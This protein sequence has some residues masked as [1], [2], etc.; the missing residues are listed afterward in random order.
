MQWT[1]T[2]RSP[3]RFR[4]CLLLAV[5]LVTGC[6]DGAGGGNSNSDPADESSRA[7]APAVATSALVVETAAV[8]GGELTVLWRFAM[9]DDWH[10]Y[11]SGRNDSGYAPS[12][13]LATAPGWETGPLRWPLPRRLVQAGD[14]L[15]HVYEGELILIQTLAVPADLEVGSQVTLAA[16]LAWLACRQEC[17]PGKATVTLTLPV[18]GGTQRTSAGEAALRQ[19]ESLLPMAVPAGGLAF[20]W[21]GTTLN[22]N[23]PGARTLE[24]Y[25]A[26]ECGDL[27]DLLHDGESATDRLAL[28]F[29]T[30]A[31]QA[32]PARGVLRV[33]SGGTAPAAW[34]LEISPTSIPDSGG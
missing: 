17:V 27:V 19:A 5:L 4:I 33:D 24:F 10:L 34:Y 32:G 18:A 16:D 1:A 23:V 7:D 29:R 6:G 14:I 25:P 31:G 2:T 20:R 3:R 21:E 28:R 22:L 30:T 12:V 15:D 8:P 13:T 26:W 11:W 9:A